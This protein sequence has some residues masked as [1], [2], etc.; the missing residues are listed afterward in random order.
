MKVT[1]YKSIKDV[2]PYQNKDV[3]FYLDR[4]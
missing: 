2:S 1:F 3:G 4:I